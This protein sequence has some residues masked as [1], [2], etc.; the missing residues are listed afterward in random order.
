MSKKILIITDAWA[1]QVNGV[2]TV[3]RETLKRL[4]ESDYEVKIVHPG[5][6]FGMPLPFY[7]EI[8]FVPFGQ[9]VI[10]KIIKQF[11]PD[12]IHIDTESAL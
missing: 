2:V 8:K 11:K 7:P 3:M 5:M 4:P 6:F 10:R 12:Y 9:G 1:P